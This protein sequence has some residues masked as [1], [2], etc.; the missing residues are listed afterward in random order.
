MMLQRVLEAGQQA[1]MYGRIRAVMLG[2]LG[3]H[4]S[5]PLGNKV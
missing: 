1:V 3:S 4:E 2:I 5:P